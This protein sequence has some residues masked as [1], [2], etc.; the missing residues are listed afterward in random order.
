MQNNRS[1][2]EDSLS[3]MR[4]DFEE[5]MGAMCDF[6][7][8]AVEGGASA[9]SQ[10]MSEAPKRPP[11]HPRVLADELGRMRARLDDFLDRLS[12]QIPEEDTEPGEVAAEEPA[13]TEE[14][15]ENKIAGEGSELPPSTERR[16]AR[17]V[18]LRAAARGMEQA[19]AGLE[20]AV[21]AL[22]DADAAR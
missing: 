1:S 13:A 21:D 16:D 8:G 7:R 12:E 2:F 20:I 11:V 15:L 18:A 6:V 19:V 10:R 22:L 3:K 5:V 17:T 9:A 4:Q 14:E